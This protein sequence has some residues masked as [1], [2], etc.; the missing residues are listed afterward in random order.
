LAARRPASLVILNRN[1][2]LTSIR[3]ATFIVFAF[4]EQELKF[5]W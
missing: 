5:R 4:F 2:L 1:I 3:A